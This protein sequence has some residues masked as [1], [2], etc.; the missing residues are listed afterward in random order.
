MLKKFFRGLAESKEKKQQTRYLKS[1]ESMAVKTV[2][3]G[4]PALA[5]TVR[6]VA[7]VKH[8]LDTSESLEKASESLGVDFDALVTT[9]CDRIRDKITELTKLRHGLP[10]AI[11]SVDEKKLSQHLTQWQNGLTSIQQAYAALQRTGAEKLTPEIEA[12]TSNY[13]TSTPLGQAIEALLLEVRTA[14]RIQ[15]ELGG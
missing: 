7:K 5:E 9:V 11:G 1:L 15:K 10:A 8:Q 12:L 6:M 2:G 4:A 14:E 3:Q 13:D